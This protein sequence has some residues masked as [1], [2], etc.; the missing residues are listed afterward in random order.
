M[1]RR[2]N[3]DAAAIRLHLR[4]RLRLLVLVPLLT[5][6]VTILAPRSESSA[7]PTAVA[8]KS[9]V[10]TGRGDVYAFSSHGVLPFF[11]QM[12]G[13]GNCE[14]TQKRIPWQFQGYTYM[15]TAALHPGLRCPFSGPFSMLLYVRTGPAQGA[16]VIHATPFDYPS[17]YGQTPLDVIDPA[18]GGVEG[19]GDL[20]ENI[21]GRCVTMEAVYEHSSWHGRI[22]LTLA[23]VPTAPV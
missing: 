17:D 11:V 16:I 6:A 3:S 5:I 10:C 9:L 7:V 19:K 2:D 8:L 12:G 1:R 14:G 21:F 20:S 13:N 23:F 4:A 15:D 18:T 22:A